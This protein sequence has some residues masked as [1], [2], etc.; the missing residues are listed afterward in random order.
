MNYLTNVESL[1]GHF[2]SFGGP[3]VARGL[4]APALN[5]L[6]RYVMSTRLTEEQKIADLK[7]F[8][9]AES[10]KFINES[11]KKI[12]VTRTVKDLPRSG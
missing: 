3:Q 2:E 9:K 5:E 1:R 11:G 7:W 6:I 4:D 10:V 12:D 8:W